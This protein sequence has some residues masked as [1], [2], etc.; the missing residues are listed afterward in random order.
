MKIRV[1]LILLSFLVIIFPQKQVAAGDGPEVIYQV[2]V[3]ASRAGNIEKLLE[4]SSLAKVKEFHQEFTTPEKQEEIRKLMKIMAPITY[5]INKTEISPDGKKASLFLD[6]TA[7]DFFT[8]N[9]PKAKP[10]KENME[11]RLVKE[12]DL[13]KIDQQCNGKDGCGKEPEWQQASFGKPI[14]FAKQ[15][16]LKVSPAQH[17]EF[18]TMKLN[19]QAYSLDFVF[20]FPENSSL[21]YFLHRSPTFAE[22]YLQVGE[23]KISPIA[24]LEIFPMDEGKAK[25]A[26]V[27]EDGVS[28]SRSHQFSGKGT[29]SLLF[30]LPKEAKGAKDLRFIVTV[31][32][33]KSSF[34][35]K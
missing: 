19:G 24:S 7:R 13:W 2:W 5:K 25:Q 27:L 11:V 26:Q 29:L 8:L 3:E 4:V 33:Q 9:D 18:K 30:D 21:F 14:S 32:D 23:T 6:A 17:P 22:F 31:N 15:A 34:Q 16:S 10:E 28:Y 20:T 35:I 1:S 12:G